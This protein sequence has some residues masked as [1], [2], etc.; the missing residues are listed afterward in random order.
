M[1]SSVQRKSRQNKSGRLKL[2]LQAL[3]NFLKIMA[4]F[5]KVDYIAIH[6]INVNGNFFMSSLITWNNSCSVTASNVDLL[7]VFDC[8]STAMSLIS[9]GN[10]FSN[11]TYLSPVLHVCTAWKHLEEIGKINQTWTFAYQGVRNVRFSENLAGF[12][13]QLPPFWDSP[14]YLTTDE[15]LQLCQYHL[16]E[17]VCGTG[18]YQ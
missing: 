8:Q 1:K 11:L 7:Y 13:F 2:K 16:P 9:S 18:L 3:K 12:V 17:N 6:Q 10:Y 15:L 14:F 5:S 4:N